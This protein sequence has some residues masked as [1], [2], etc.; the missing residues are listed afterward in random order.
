MR[1]PHQDKRGL[2]PSP[3]SVIVYVRMARKPESPADHA[4]LAAQRAQVRRAHVLG[5]P[6]AAISVIEDLGAG[7]HTTATRP[8]Y[9]RLC[10]LVAAR[11]VRV[12]LVSDL[13]RLSRSVRNWQAFRLLCRRTKTRLLV[14]DVDLDFRDVSASPRS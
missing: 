3:Q 4:R 13:S 9:R 7:G 11:R 14:A 5:V 6:A 10:Y 1:R 2:Q 12:V 8:G